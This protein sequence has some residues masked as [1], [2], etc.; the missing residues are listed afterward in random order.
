[1]AWKRKLVTL[2]ADLEE[3]KRMTDD[4]LM[5]EAGSMIIYAVPSG[6]FVAVSTTNA[7]MSKKEVL[8]ALHDI[9]EAIEEHGIPDGPM[10]LKKRIM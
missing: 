3:L 6:D 7:S 9:A 5:A 1:M 10:V 2:P 8:A 4:E